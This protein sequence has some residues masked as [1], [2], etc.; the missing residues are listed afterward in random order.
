[1]RLAGFEISD[2][3]PMVRTEPDLFAM[4][5]TSAICGCANLE[6][7]EADEAE[8]DEKGTLRFGLALAGS[9]KGKVRGWEG[10]RGSIFIDCAVGAMSCCEYVLG[11][12]FSRSGLASPEGAEEEAEAEDAE[13][14][15]VDAEP[16]GTQAGGR[17]ANDFPPNPNLPPPPPP[18]PP[19]PGGPR[20]VRNWPGGA[21]G[22]LEIGF[23]P[24]ERGCDDPVPAGTLSL[25]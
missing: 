17:G 13:A 21:P 12:L 25:R 10:L 9:R 2:W 11:C 15:A 8:S 1:M 14:A 22:A 4:G 19:I 6:E 23:I 5:V 20:F 16:T 3:I 18:G 7:P 24:C